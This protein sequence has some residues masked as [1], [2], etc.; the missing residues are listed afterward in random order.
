MQA[1]KRN[2][3]RFPDDFM[4]QL[5]WEEVAALRS[6]IVTLNTGVPRGRQMLIG[7]RELAQKLAA[8]ERKYDGSSAW[9]L[10]PSRS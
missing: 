2:L 4:F 8:L 9:C 7:N 3:T 6:Q 10:T 1:V 5:T